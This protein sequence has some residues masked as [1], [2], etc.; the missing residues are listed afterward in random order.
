M[1]G[2]ERCTGREVSEALVLDGEL[3]VAEAV[4]RKGGGAL[5]LSVWTVRSLLRGPCTVK[6]ARSL[7]LA[8]GHI[9]SEANTAADALS[10][11][12]GPC[13]ER[14]PWPFGSSARMEVGRSLRPMSLWNL[15]L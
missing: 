9:P 2:A 12:V 1:L 8:V 3:V 5:K 6:I 14:K 11:Q 4:R 15:L 13:S 7:K 10:R